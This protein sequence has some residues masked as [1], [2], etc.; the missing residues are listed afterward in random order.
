MTELQ[1]KMLE[2]LLEQLDETCV[3]IRRDETFASAPPG[4]AAKVESFVEGMASLKKAAEGTKSEFH[5]RSL[6]RLVV[7]PTGR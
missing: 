7:A 6:V 3:R 5:W 1:K 4:V 2:R